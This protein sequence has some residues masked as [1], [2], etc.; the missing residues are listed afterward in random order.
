MCLQK[1]IQDRCSCS[2]PFFETAKQMKFC[3]LGQDSDDYSCVTRVIV[4][5]DIGERTCECGAPCLE[6]DYE[7]LVTSTIWPGKQ[8]S[9]TFSELYKVCL[10]N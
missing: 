8:A 9:L 1:T 6:T 5:Y 4:E 10:W 3:D 2:H 7:K